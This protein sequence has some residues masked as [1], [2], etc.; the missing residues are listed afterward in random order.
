MKLVRSTLLISAAVLTVAATAQP[1][2]PPP[3]QWRAVAH[4]TGTAYETGTFDQPADGGLRIACTSDGAALLSVQIKG[5]APAAGRRFLVIPATRRGKAQSFAFT[6]DSDGTVR[7]PTARGDRQLGK[8]W[9]ALRGGNNA[10]IRYLDGSFS[11]Q[12]LIGATATLPARVC[13]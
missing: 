13:G 7:F 12:S 9:A 6:A 3:G 10:T 8:L 2:A 5:A 4:A 1:A 11:V